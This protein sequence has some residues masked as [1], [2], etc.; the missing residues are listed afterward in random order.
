MNKTPKPFN[1][2]RRAVLKR[3]MVA[4]AGAVAAGTLLRTQPA[5]AAK[6]SKAAM[7]Y[8]DKPH[9]KQ[10]CA[11]CVQFIPGSTPKAQGGCQVVAGKIDPHGWCVAFTPKA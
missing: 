11:G 9:G 2:S 7:M 1:A 3:G 4:A 10:E 5:Q 6:A 8:Q